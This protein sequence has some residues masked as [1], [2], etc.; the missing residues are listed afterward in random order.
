MVEILH[1]SRGLM[2]GWEVVM[3]E[4]T[5]ETVEMVGRRGRESERTVY[6]RF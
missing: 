6:G 5:V 4:E 1:H 2:H 3:V